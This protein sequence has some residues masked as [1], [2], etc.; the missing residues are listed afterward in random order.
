MY[1]CAVQIPP[2]TAQD[3]WRDVQRPEVAV[4]YCVSNCHLF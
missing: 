1:A 4:Q 2:E 3:D